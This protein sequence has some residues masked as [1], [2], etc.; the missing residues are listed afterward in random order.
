M[1]I[2]E[3]YIANHSRGRMPIK[4]FSRQGKFIRNI[5]A[6]GRGPGEFTSLY[7]IQL[8]EPANRI[9]LTPFA[10]AKEIIVYNLEGE[11]QKPIPLIYKQTKCK[12]YIENKVVTVLSMPFS[13]E[14]PVAYQQTIA[15][16]LIQKLPVIDHIILKRDFSSEISSSNN[17]GAYDL[18]VLAYGGK[19]LD[20]L[21][22]YNTEK[23]E[24]VPKYVASFSD[25][26]HGSW[27]YEWR[28][29]YFSWIFGKKYKGR[30][31][32]V[33]KKTLK[34]DF[35]KIKNDFYGDFE[36]NK[37]FMSNNRMFISTI[38]PFELITKFE[39]ALENDELSA[40]ERQKI[41]TLQKTLDENDNE[42]LF[43]GEMK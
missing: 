28:S 42:V 18:F 39:K 15:G 38:S 34:S 7:G 2:S 14:I 10:N 4:L 5:G 37:F 16:E 19:A 12:V 40:K 21:Y 22:Y 26:K 11:N 6:I 13:D 24:L 17:A 3:K 32:I 43:I 36:I 23:N 9:Y 33:D 1:G 31:V 30:K 8:D 41:E 20:T 35:F 29:H 27:T 25:K